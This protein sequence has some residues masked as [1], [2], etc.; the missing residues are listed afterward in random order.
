MRPDVLG[1]VLRPPDLGAGDA[2][3]RLLDLREPV[4]DDG[5]VAVE[6]EAHHPAAD[7]EL[8]RHPVDRVLRHRALAVVPEASLRQH[9]REQR[10][11]DDL[12]DHPD[13]P[14]ERQPPQRVDDGGKVVVPPDAQ[15]ERHVAL[16]LRH[17][18]HAHLRDDAE[19]RLHEELIG[20]RAEPALVHVPGAAARQR[21][22]ARAHDLAVREHDLH[23]AL[24]AHVD[25]VRQ[26]RGAV[27]ER[28]ADDAPPADVGHREHELVAARLDRLVQVEP[29]HARLD[30]RIPE[31]LVDLE[32]AVHPPQAHEH[33]SLHARRRA[34]VPV[35][36]SGRVRPQRHAVPRGDADDL[37]HLLD[38]RRHHDRRAGVVVPRR[39]LE[40]VA[41]LAQVVLR[42]EHALRTEERLEVAERRREGA[43][44]NGG[45]HLTVSSRDAARA[46]SANRSAS[47]SGREKNGAWLDSSSSTCCARGANTLR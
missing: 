28:V 16:R 2:P 31:L 10:R 17:E 23:A 18:P 26:V 29:A 27:L 6:R 41:E 40:R 1:R 7:L 25:A 3:E 42:R 4:V 15:P 20:R 32:H 8:P 24:R 21:A 14:V 35:V 38:R 12:R 36:A 43:C 19:V 45:A 47:S 13:R 44:R 30:D 5:L 39:V 46:R 9:G 33:R 37:L 34:A 22:H 11:V